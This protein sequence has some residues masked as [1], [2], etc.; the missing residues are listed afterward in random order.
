MGP[1]IFKWDTGPGTLH[2]LPYTRDP[3]PDTLYVRPSIQGANTWDQSKKTHFVYQSVVF[4]IFLILIYT[5]E[6][7]SQFL[8]SAKWFQIKTC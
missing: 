7:S 5:L 3:G 8:I 4:C 1:G 6:F 2:L